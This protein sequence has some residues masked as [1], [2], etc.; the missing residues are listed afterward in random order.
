MSPRT[1]ESAWVLY[2]GKSHLVSAI[3]DLIVCLFDSDI[4]HTYEIKDKE[5]CYT[6][7]LKLLNYDTRI[8]KILDGS[9]CR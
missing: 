2:N 8:S 3:I 9:D 7:Q 4:F 5:S 1:R 6:K